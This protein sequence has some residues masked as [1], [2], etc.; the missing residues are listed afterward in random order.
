MDL[1]QVWTSPGEDE[2]HYMQITPWY[3]EWT[4]ERR[5]NQKGKNITGKS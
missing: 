3:M 5:S 1:S 4:G 2:W